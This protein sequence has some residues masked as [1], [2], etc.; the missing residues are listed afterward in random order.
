MYID[1]VTW[2]IWFLGFA[3]LV[4]WLIIPIKEIKKLLAERKK[5]Q[6]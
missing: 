5:N 6:L 2:S 4:V 3:I 1:Y